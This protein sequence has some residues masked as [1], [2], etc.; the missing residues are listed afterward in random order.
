MLTDIEKFVLGENVAHDLRSLQK[1]EKDWI[2]TIAPCT[3]C[4]EGTSSKT[5]I[6]ANVEEEYEQLLLDDGEELEFPLAIVGF[7]SKPAIAGR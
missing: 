1:I 2:I 7:E 4:T 5:F 3:E 6:F